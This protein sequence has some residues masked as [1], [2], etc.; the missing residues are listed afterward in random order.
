MPA[1]RLALLTL[2]VALI[3]SLGSLGSATSARAAAPPA[4]PPTV[5]GPQSVQV[6]L[7][8]VTPGVAT[9]K[10]NVTVVGSI[11]NLG[12]EPLA[13][14][15]VRA[16]LTSSG[17]DTRPALAA[18]ADGSS[19]V[20]PGRNVGQTALSGTLKPRGSTSFTI[21]IASDKLPT[22]FTYT[23]LGLSIDVVDGTGSRVGTRASFLPFDSTTA[24]SHA[25]PIDIS[26]V[27]PITLDADAALFGADSDARTKA[28]RHAIG[29]G[30]RVDRLIEATTHAPVTWAV[31]P[32]LVE[33][34]S[35]RV[36]TAPTPTASITP[37][38][39]TAA[40]TSGPPAPKP[41]PTPTPKSTSP[42]TPTP[43]T[44]G[45]QPNAA[46]PVHELASE[47]SKRLR[48]GHPIWTLPAADPDLTALLDVDPGGGPLLTSVLALP[49][50]ASLGPT[51]RSDIAWPI[52]GR[53][54]DARLDALRSLW[55]T[56]GGLGAVVTSTTTLDGPVGYT[57]SAARRSH[58]G[59]P[60]LAYDERLSGVFASMSNPADGG[61]S[62]QR[63]L[64][65][66]LA[67]YQERPAQPRSLLVV[68]PRGF[69]GDPAV[70]TALFTQVAA[71]HW[72]APTPTTDLV[73][74]ASNAPAEP[75]LA[76]RAAGQPAAPGDLTAYP[77]AAPSPLTA[78][79]LASLAT[80]HTGI[81][82]VS[83]V[84]ANG[85]TFATVWN[86]VAD[87]LLSSRWRQAG[88]SQRA[89]QG[90]RATATRA[91]ATVAKGVR[92][93]PSTF[94]FF[95]DA[96]ALQLTV[97]N[98]LDVAVKNV[99]LDLAP[100]N[101]RLR[102][103]EQPK[104][105]RIGADSRTT[106]RVRVSAISAGLVPVDAT[107]SSANGTPIGK[108]TLVTVHVQPTSTWIYWVLGIVAGLLLVLGLYRGLRTGPRA[109]HPPGAEADDTDEP[110]PRNQ[111]RPPDQPHP[112]DAHTRPDPPTETPAP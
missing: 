70:L 83:S 16:R 77:A 100:G 53:L 61:A 55:K 10:T 48:T 69:A 46:D 81:T 93:V 13:K 24:A 7:V 74:S 88:A 73:A 64:A 63:F 84:L 27:V 102:I 34:P 104:P 111:P 18:W 106:V 51:D 59:V 22:G 29:P 103:L 107:L 12:T 66:T 97:I 20:D 98:E 108:A 85:A 23:T 67:A 2:V 90:L 92:V 5:L 38:S 56:A 25:Q 6:R 35:T 101:P 60:L 28:W 91:V 45:S 95:A 41:T 11:I 72:L 30:S 42:P 65:E 31:D 62:V 14:P 33:P 54:D 89:W 86:G 68:P 32:T 50:P 82:G 49:A 80:L 8:S 112:P 1:A 47:L 37:T 4:G 75:P 21:T 26:W 44:A 19:E 40:P 52:G 78:T 96:G 17:L 9:P 39:P 109:V 15:I 79:G 43:T 3:T 105:L 58:D 57:G 76:S 110:G 71:A 99:H 87:Q 94:N 36:P